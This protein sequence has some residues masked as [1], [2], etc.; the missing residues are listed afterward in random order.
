MENQNSR[1]RRKKKQEEKEK[2][3]GS[4]K[5]S[6]RMEDLGQK[7]RSSEVRRRC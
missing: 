7:G 3:N 1:S 6:R 5:S 4:K 2:N